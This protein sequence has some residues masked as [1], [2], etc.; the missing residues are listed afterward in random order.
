MVRY[1][2]MAWAGVEADHMLGVG[3]VDGFEGLNSVG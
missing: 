2:E 3:V 1:V